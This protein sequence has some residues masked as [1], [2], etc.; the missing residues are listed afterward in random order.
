MVSGF[1]DQEDIM[2]VKR[3]AWILFWGSGLTAF[4]AAILAWISVVPGTALLDWG[5]V[6]VNLILMNLQWGI[7][8]GA[9]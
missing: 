8:H 3:N 7:I 1:N 6:G 2:S 9:K 4:G 5:L